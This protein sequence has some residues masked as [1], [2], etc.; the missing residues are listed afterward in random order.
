MRMWTFKTGVIVICFQTS[1]AQSSGTALNPHSPLSLKGTPC[2]HQFQSCGLLNFHQSCQDP[3][4]G[5]TTF[6]KTA[7][8]FYL[9][10]GRN[11]RALQRLGTWESQNFRTHLIIP[12]KISTKFTIDLHECTAKLV[13]SNFAFAFS[14]KIWIYCLTLSRTGRECFNI[15]SK[16][17]FY[18]FKWK[19]YL[20]I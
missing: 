8:A 11:K 9:Y 5:T 18:V 4:M 17:S 3:A 1:R 16:F 12:I 19:L 13:V 14:E 7:D 15:P 6:G 20:N 10:F 2:L